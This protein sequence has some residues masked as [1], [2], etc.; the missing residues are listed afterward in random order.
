MGFQ[1]VYTIVAELTTLEPDYRQVDNQN[2]ICNPT[3]RI[4]ADIPSA[5]FY[6]NMIGMHY[7]RHNATVSIDGTGEDTTIY[8]DYRDGKNRRIHIRFTIRET[9]IISQSNIFESKID[10]DPDLIIRFFTPTEEIKTCEE[11]VD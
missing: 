4:F 8:V 2:G 11:K 3:D 1:T 7:A 10:D 6:L 5:V 9:D